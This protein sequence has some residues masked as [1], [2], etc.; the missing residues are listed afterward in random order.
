MA[1]AARRARY[2]IAVAMLV[3]AGAALSAVPPEITAQG[4]D[5]ENSQPGELGQFQRLRVRF[6]VP[7][8]IAE[9]TIRERSY[10]VDLASTPE[11]DHLPLFGLNR[12]VRQLTDVTLDFQSYINSKI[13]SAGSYEF[14][15][16]VADR[17]G[18]RAQAVLRVEVSGEPATSQ[19]LDSD[20][21]DAERFRAV[22]VGAAAVSGSERLG[23][24][25]K[26]IESNRVVIRL[27][28]DAPDGYFFNLNAEDYTTLTTQAQLRAAARRGVRQPTLEL[29][30]A[31]NRSAGQ[32]FGLFSSAAPRLLK[33]TRSHTS[34]SEVGT[35]VTLEG[36]FKF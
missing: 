28:A 7:G 1:Y 18:E 3:A 4:F 35:T 23:F 12:Q 19:R 29:A 16:S 34:L 33:V 11:V 31:A 21:L 25:W 22:R 24:T 8:R 10:E 14:E 32:V 9:L 36:E 13:D 27:A 26:T 2:T 15:L 5:I 20:A 30:A 17:S 6:E